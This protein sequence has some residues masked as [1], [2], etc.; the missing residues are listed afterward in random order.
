[1]LPPPRNI[2]VQHIRSLYLYLADENNP[3]REGRGN[4][5]QAHLVIR[6]IL[7]LLPFDIL[8]RFSRRPWG[9]FK[10]DNLLLLYKR[11]RKLKSIEVT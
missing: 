1:M 5:E 7:E 2:G 10:A 8:E 9:P 3:K 4:L 6:M 11:Q